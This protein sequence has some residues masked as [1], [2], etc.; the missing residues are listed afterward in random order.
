MK[1]DQLQFITSIIGTDGAS[2]LSKAVDRC[3][4]LEG[5]LV[6]RS[7]LS[8]INTIGS[9]GYEGTIPGVDNSY[10]S[11]EKA[12]N[13]YQGSVN[14]G[15]YMYN[16]EKSTV[17]HLASALALSIGVEANK[18]I[19]VKDL[20]I[21]KLGKSIDLLIK[22]KIIT[23]ELGKKKEEL[24]KQA[25]EG[26]GGG[27][28]AIEPAP[29]APPTAPTQTAAVAPAALK[30]PKVKLPKPSKI[31]IFKSELTHK[32]SLCGKGS[33]IENSFVGCMCL[34]DLAKSVKT[35]GDTLV[36]GEDWDSD[37]IIT[38]YDCVGRNE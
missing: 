1:P 31:K 6:P 36:L 32:C 14:I 7:I 28:G 30:A 8:W 2:A 27:A 11:F 18:D 29:A 37:A 13:G 20:D 12:E 9:I 4:S 16:F 33:F 35:V 38:L 10:L 23:N 15:E 5:V 34:S 3:E 21:E 17:F 22:A 19:D 26:A 25:P 24:D